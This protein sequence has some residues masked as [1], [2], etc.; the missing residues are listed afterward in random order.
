M[1]YQVDF[2]AVGDGERSGDAIAVRFGD[3]EGSRED[4]TV[5]VIDGGTKDSGEQ[6][7][8]HIRIHYST[9]KVDYVICLIQMQIMP[10]AFLLS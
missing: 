8:E 4:Q 3:I 10:Q 2:M 7:C 1:G 5:L 6:L 9:E